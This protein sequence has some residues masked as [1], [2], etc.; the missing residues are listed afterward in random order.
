MLKIIVSDTSPISYLI[1]ID[2]LSLLEALYGEIII[3][4]AVYQEIL[5]L[6]NLGYNLS[7]F[8]N[9]KWIKILNP[10]DI[11]NIHTYVN[12]LIKAN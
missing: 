11:S 5:Q 8:K 1:K 12:I 7:V 3:P 9:S 10:I 4:E 6:E 2:K